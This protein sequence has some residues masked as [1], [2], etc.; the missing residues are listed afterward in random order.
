[1]IPGAGFRLP[2]GTYMV[3][4]AVQD[5]SGTDGGGRAQ[6]GVAV[7]PALDALTLRPDFLLEGTPHTRDERSFFPNGALQLPNGSVAV[8]YM[9]QA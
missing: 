9:G 3:Y 8:T 2:N 1:M 6:M 7:G 5:Y 4:V